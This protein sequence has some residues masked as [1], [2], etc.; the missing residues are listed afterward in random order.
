MNIKCNAQILA[1]ASKTTS[2]AQRERERERERQRAKKREHAEIN[3][4]LDLTQSVVC[5]YIV[6]M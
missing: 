4:Q 5:L 2:P 1:A 3:W 6:M